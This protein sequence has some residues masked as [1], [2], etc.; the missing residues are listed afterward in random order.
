LLLE[1]V[2]KQQVLV[3]VDFS[4]VSFNAIK[5]A[6]EVARIFKSE[7]SLLT[8]IND[9][10]NKRN[11]FNEEGSAKDKLLPIAKSIIE[12][13]KIPVNVYVVKGNYI[14]IIN[15]MIEVINA[16]MIVAGL[17]KKN[18]T[19][20]FTPRILSTKFRSLRIPVLIVQKR[21]PSHIPFK[22]II[23]PVDFRKQSKEKAPWS[24]YFSKLN[25]SKI[26]IVFKE[27]KDDYFLKQ[28]HNNMTLI[29]KSFDTMTVDYSIYKV[30]NIN[31]S[32]DKYAVSYARMNLADLVIILNT[33]DFA[34][35]DQLFGPAEQRLML[36]QEQVPL[37][38]LNPRDDLFI[39]CV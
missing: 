1:K 20:Y 39:P 35:D 3:P 14:K 24:S 19:N 27:Y 10:S 4:E 37:L 32:I 8:V 22:N 38:C 9:N 28:L 11:I 33:D 26:H 13:Y 29:K 21:P 23:L 16:I 15:S 34:I 17:D 12:L 7:I 2:K 25:N 30:K 18:K 6:I 36:N 5:Y 31:C